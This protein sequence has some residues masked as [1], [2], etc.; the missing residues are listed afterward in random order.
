MRAA[1]TL[2]Y[3]SPEQV[4]GERVDSRTDIYSA[5]AV[6]YEMS[7]GRRPF[8]ET[9][10]PRLIEA[11]LYREPSRPSDVNR[12]MTPGLENVLLKALDKNPERRYQS[13]RELAIDL[14]RLSSDGSA[15]V[16]PRQPKKRKVWL[17]GITVTM[18]IGV[19]AVAL[20]SARHFFIT[21]KPKSIV[22]PVSPDFTGGKRL[23]VLP[24]EVDGDQA[25]MGYIAD[26]IV[27]YLN[28]R[29]S[30]LNG[31]KLSDLNEVGVVDLTQPL[32]KVGRALGVNLVLR[33]LIRFSPQELHVV[34]KLQNVNQAQP[35]WT[36][37]FSENKSKISVLE[38]QMYNEVLTA[39]DITESEDEK[40]RGLTRPVVSDATYELYLKGRERMSTRQAEPAPEQA[41]QFYEEALKKDRNFDLAYIGLAD[42]NLFLYQ[43]HKSK[44]FLRR[45]MDAA[46]HAVQLDNASPTAHYCLARV[47]EADSEHLQ[48]VE[49]LKKV[50][51]LLPSSDT[52]YRRLGE[53]HLANSDRAHAI[54]AFEKAVELNS[55]YWVNQNQLGDAYFRMEEYGKALEAFKHVTVL[56]PDVDAGYENIGNVYAQQGKYQEAV[57]YFQKALQIEPY[58]S[59]Y[60]NLGTCYFFLKQYALAVE[61]FE[62]AV[63]MNRADTAMMVNMADSYRFLG[64]QERARAAYR[65]ALLLGNREL[66]TN[67]KNADV[68]AQIALCYSNLGDV[69]QAELFMKKARAID[70]NNLDYM[71][72]Q[73]QVY[74]L[75]GKTEEALNA[76]QNVLQRNYPTDVVDTD[77]DLNSL[78]DD[79]EFK[80]LL[81]KYSSTKVPAPPA[82]VAPH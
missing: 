26:G 44:P 22:Q 75:L 38:D 20:Y 23:A 72:D 33:S 45:A 82:A 6:L 7:T 14:V 13:A 74:A 2:P 78:H 63:G 70:G 3:M 46:R 68:M 31:L 35:F 37:E 57:P 54:E 48:A 15:L 51:S 64:K 10:A 41:I 58:Y 71:Y 52:A 32:D 27:E 59:T 53:A 36:H 1:G 18:F 29:F 21:H 47:Y 12:R 16:L 49:E 73:V 61:M 81:H 5:G 24:I 4:R 9:Q 39:L 55:D 8:P 65:Q 25:S 19:L 66:K 17:L 30:Q 62:K 76:L 60:S 67:P 34:L 42:A 56:V 80:N 28:D 43:K 69:Q 77:P 79:P 50:V 11:I 40:F